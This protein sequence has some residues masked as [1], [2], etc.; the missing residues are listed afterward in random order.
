MPVNQN[1]CANT[2]KLN[3]LT[4]QQLAHYTGMSKSFYEKRRVNKQAPPYIKIGGRVFYRCPDIDAWL[5]GSECQPGE[6]S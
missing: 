1:T 2:S 3:L 6:A 5:T 4:T